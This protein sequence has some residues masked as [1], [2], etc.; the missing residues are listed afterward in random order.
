VRR[1]ICGVPRF[2]ARLTYIIRGVG[3]LLKIPADR[4]AACLSELQDCL[5]HID[6]LIKQNPA[7]NVEWLSEFQWTDDGRL[8]TEHVLV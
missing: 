6:G 5:A 3:D 2:V 4:R 8:N 7:V 1:R